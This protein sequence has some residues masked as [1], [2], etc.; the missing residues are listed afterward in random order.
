MAPCY[1]RYDSSTKL[2]SANGYSQSN[3]LLPYFIHRSVMVCTFT[4]ISLEV[5]QFSELLLSVFIYL[6]LSHSCVAYLG[7]CCLPV[8]YE[9]VQV[10]Y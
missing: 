8:W 5:I 3:L 1:S 9:T 10:R 4:V 6:H 7:R 2:Q